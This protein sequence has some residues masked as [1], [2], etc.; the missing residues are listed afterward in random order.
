MRISPVKR[1]RKLM[2]NRVQQG[3]RG[4]QIYQILILQYCRN[5][6]LWFKQKFRDPQSEKSSED[7]RLQMMDRNQKNLHRKVQRKEMP[8]SLV[9]KREYVLP[10]I[11]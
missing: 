10:L 6:V 9:K 3:P 11:Q 2:R 7:L 8:K 1:D 4:K 5:P